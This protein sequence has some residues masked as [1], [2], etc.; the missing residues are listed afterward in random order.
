MMTVL[1]IHVLIEARVTYLFDQIDV[2]KC[3]IIDHYR[4][5]YLLT[6]VYTDQLVDF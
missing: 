3:V 4:D 2:C 6:R 1:D 5:K